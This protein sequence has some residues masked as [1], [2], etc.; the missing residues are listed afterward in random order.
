MSTFSFDSGFIMSAVWREQ[1]PAIVESFCMQ[2]DHISTSNRGIMLF[3][4]PDD[5]VVPVMTSFLAHASDWDSADIFSLLQNLYGKSKTF[6]STQQNMLMD[7][8][9][10]FLQ[11]IYAQ[12]PHKAFSVFGWIAQFFSYDSFITIVEHA[13][14]HTWDWQNTSGQQTLLKIWSKGCL[15]STLWSHIQPHQWAQVDHRHLDWVASHPTRIPPQ[16]K[17]HTICLYLQHSR[18]TRDLF[19]VDH[20]EDI[21]ALSPTL[22][23]LLYLS[24][25]N[26]TLGYHTWLAEHEPRMMLWIEERERS[27]QMTGACYV[28]L[29]DWLSAYQ[30]HHQSHLLD[31]CDLYA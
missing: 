20:L 27:N 18:N 26:Q 4:I 5:I 17:D 23:F 14:S 2:Y 11:K 10:P 12:D 19:V 24:P 31:E 21:P 25:D 1:Y 30:D 6:S 28:T 29:E 16:Y 7:A 8:V 13:G 15:P 22:C 9:V 3:S